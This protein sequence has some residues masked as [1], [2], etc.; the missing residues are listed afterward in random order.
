MWEKKN[1]DKQR[2]RDAKTEKG[3]GWVRNRP[4]ERKTE[5]NRETG[6]QRARNKE[7]TTEKERWEERWK[8]TGSKIWK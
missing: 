4:G 7:R 1:G 5:R 8:E 3:L 6:K 2:E